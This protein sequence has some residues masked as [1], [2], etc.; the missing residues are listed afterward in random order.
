LALTLVR[1][2][3]IGSLAES[4]PTIVTDKLD[5]PPTALAFATSSPRED[6][7][8]D[9]ADKVCACIVGS[10]HAVRKR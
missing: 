4:Q 3:A 8:L 7:L 10:L 2:N 6:I 5:A 1:I 9:V